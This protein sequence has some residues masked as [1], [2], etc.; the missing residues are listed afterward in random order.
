[1]ESGFGLQNILDL[2]LQVFTVSGGAAWVSTF[3]TNKRG[4]NSALNFVMD[5][6]ELVAGN[7]GKASN[8]KATG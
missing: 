3:I 5:L 4:E 1:M 6:F 7:V 2:I 8:D